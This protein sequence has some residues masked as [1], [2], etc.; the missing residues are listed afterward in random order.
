[1]PTRY[2]DYNPS[3]SHPGMPASTPTSF[4]NFV[5]PR[6]FANM[7]Q[8]Q[9]PPRPSYQSNRRDSSMVPTQGRRTPDRSF[10]RSSV[11]RSGGPQGGGQQGFDPFMMMGM[12]DPN[13]WSG[14][15]YQQ[16]LTYIQALFR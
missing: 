7:N 13:T 6:P 1:M 14:Q 11:I 9:Q 8:P 16:L 12:T 5:A 2:F 4:Q 15:D 3:Y 10:S